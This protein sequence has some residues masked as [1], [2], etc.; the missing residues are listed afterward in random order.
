MVSV[1]AVQKGIANY[2]DKN[3]LSQ[4]TPV[5][6]VIKGGLIGIYI[7]GLPNIIEGYVKQAG[8]DKIGVVTDKGIDID[9]I[10]NSFATQFQNAGAIPF[11]VPFIGTLT[12]DAEE[13]EKI[14]QE[15][16]SCNI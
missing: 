16:L 4:M 1:V 9:V 13:I 7:N 6:K 8:L 2:I 14:Y 15:I 3:L 10:K 12:I 5:D 11:D